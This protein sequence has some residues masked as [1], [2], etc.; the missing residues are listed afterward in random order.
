MPLKLAVRDLRC[1]YERRGFDI[2]F[3]G[4]SGADISSLCK[5]AALGPIRNI[6]NI[7]TIQTD[8]VRWIITA[9]SIRYCSN[10]QM[11]IYRLDL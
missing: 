10:R 7:E 2:L 8:Q 3:S 6:D 5:D 11:P 4:Y 1:A 9:V